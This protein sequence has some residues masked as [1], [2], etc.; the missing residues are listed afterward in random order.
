LSFFSHRS[1]SPNLPP[2]SFVGPRWAN[3]EQFV[4][5]LS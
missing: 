1:P 3:R 5:Q 4:S 2:N